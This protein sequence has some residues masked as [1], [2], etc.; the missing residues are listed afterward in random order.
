MSDGQLLQCKN[1]VALPKD[2]ERFCGDPFEEVFRNTN[3]PFK[4]VFRSANLRYG[5]PKTSKQVNEA[6]KL[7][8]PRKTQDQNKWVTNVWCDWVQ[9]LLWIS[10]VEKEEKQ[11]QLLE[12]FCKMSTKDMNFWVAKFVLEVR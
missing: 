6:R 5:S 8:I 10:S 12:D 2:K 7:G 11:H 1:L 4:E 3:D 9:Y